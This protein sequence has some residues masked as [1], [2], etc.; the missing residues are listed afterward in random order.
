MTRF[1]QY[2]SCWASH[3]HRT[4]HNRTV[5]SEE[6][7]PCHKFGGTFQWRCLTGGK[8][9]QYSGSYSMASLWWTQPGSVPISS[10]CHLPGIRSVLT[11]FCMPVNPCLLVLHP[12]HFLCGLNGATLNLL[13]NVESKLNFNG[14]LLSPNSGHCCLLGSQSWMYC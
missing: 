8:V 14:S 13:S 3:L 5:I 7:I 2:N 1:D 6:W 9:C 4:E 11:S 10:D 12:L